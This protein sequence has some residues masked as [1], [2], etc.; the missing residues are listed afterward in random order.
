VAGITVRSHLFDGEVLPIIGPAVNALENVVID[1]TQSEEQI[2]AGY[3]GSVRNHVRRGRT[4]GVEITVDDNCSG[5]GEF[6]A[7]YSQTM[8]TKGAD[9][10]YFFKL[11]R[12]EQMVA[13]LGSGVALFHAHVGGRL[14][15]TEMQ[16]V[17]ARN[18]YYFLSGSIDEGRRVDANPVMKHAVVTWL[19][20]QGI[21][22]Y[23]LGGGMS[24]NDSLFKYK[25]AYSRH[26]TREF[27]VAFHEAEA[28]TAASL[29]AARRQAEPSWVPMLGFVPEYRAPVA[30][31]GETT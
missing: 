12:L 22:R 23:V 3:D 6:H 16:L 30:D 24:R 9:D 11:T 13:G 7:M 18:A 25:R 5:L 29:V 21:D 4:L 1:L 28:G 10:F 2:W 8:S 27:T 19:K 20:Q 31:P 17:G 15:A 14:V 26:N